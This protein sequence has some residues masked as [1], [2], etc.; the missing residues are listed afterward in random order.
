MKKFRK[1]PAYVFELPTL[2]SVVEA[3]KSNEED[4]EPLYQNQKVHYYAREKLYSENHSLEIMEAIIACFERRYGHL[5]CDINDNEVNVN[6]DEGD[7]V[8]F[9][10]C[11]ILITMFVRRLQQVL[12]SRKPF[13]SR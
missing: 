4:G 1:N 2:K 12:T 3:I 8:L 7:H 6:S 11:H 13:L 9:D 5:Y 10:V